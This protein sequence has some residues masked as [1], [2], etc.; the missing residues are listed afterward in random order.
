MANYVLKRLLQ[1]V[2]VFF[3]VTAL[4]FL[5]LRLA[6]G[7]AAHDRLQDRG[8]DLTAENLRAVK[9]ELGLDRPI[10]TQYGRWLGAVLRFDLGASIL[11]GEPVSAELARRFRKT[12]YLALPAMLLTL[13]AAFPLGLLAAL[14]QGRLW[15]RITRIA[16]VAVMSIPAFCLGLVFIL[17]FSVNLGWLPSFGAGSPAHL[18]MPCLVLSIASAAQYA[19]FIRSAL[20]EELSKEYVRAARARG[21]GRL[22]ILVFH[23]MKNALIPI[24]TS[25][26]MSL[27]LM[28]GGSAVVEKVFSWPGMGACLIDAVLN[29]DYPVVQGC[30][31]LYAFIF[32]GINLA[33]DLFC[34]ILDPK[35]RPAGRLAQ[36]RS[37]SDE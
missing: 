1:F 5:L 26:G 2:P 29:R 19:R 12:A 28:L 21:I 37:I 35:L 18:V 11:S 13:I 25:L 36:N 20:L 16:A 6:P 7:D 32:A 34:I 27:A 31:L 14:Y 33:A 15:D 17:V 22:T 23:G 30:V 10:W 9:A 3:G 24:I 8:M 4:V